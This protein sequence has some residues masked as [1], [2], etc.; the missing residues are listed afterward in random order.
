MNGPRKLAVH[1]RIMHAVIAEGHI[2]ENR[3][4]IIVR[5]RRILKPLA[6]IVASG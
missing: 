6:N 3:I 4:K 1:R 5:Q 2:A